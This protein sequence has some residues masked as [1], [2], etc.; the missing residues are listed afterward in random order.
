MV[1][2]RSNFEMHIIYNVCCV[3]GLHWNSNPI[4]LYVYAKFETFCEKLSYKIAIKVKICGVNR[5][6]NQILVKN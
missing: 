6:Y 5:K 4:P 3:S 1:W 2:G